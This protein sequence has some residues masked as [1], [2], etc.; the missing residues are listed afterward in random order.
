MPIFELTRESLSALPRTTMQEQFFRERQDLQRL[1][2]GSIS[3]LGEEFLVIAE[4]FS[5]WQAGK[6]IWGKE[7]VPSVFSDAH[8]CKD[9]AYQFIV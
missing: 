3:A 8:N 7:R 2:K 4:E 5:E 9:P 6:T 1:L